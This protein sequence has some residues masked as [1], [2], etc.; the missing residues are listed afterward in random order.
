MQKNLFK[1]AA[2]LLLV[3]LS[4]CSIFSDKKEVGKDVVA[5]KLYADAHDEL[6][7]GAYEQ[8]IHLFEQLE[9]N[10]PFGVY[11]QQAQM[12]IAYAYYRKGEP[13]E[14][15][16]AAERFIKLHPK[17]PNVEYVYYLRGLIN[18]SDSGNFLNVL[19]NQDL[20][21]RDPKAIREAFDAFKQLTERF[22]NSIY[23]PD[24]IARMKYLVNAM[25]Q[26]E[27]HVAKYYYRRGAYLAAVNRAQTAVND[28]QGAPATEEALFVMVRSYDKM[29]L[30][31]LRDDA[32]RVFK[33]NYPNS[34][35]LKNDGNKKPWWKI[36]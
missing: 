11:A 10:Y 27:V 20:T 33:K 26:Y 1:L 30:N 4:A 25:A 16:A 17:H 24:A 15:L 29:G 32:D 12:E 31:T 9:S 34:A 35:F 19:F 13:V 3:A 6:S 23:T 2:I 36:L 18:F 14:A 8:A 5:A 7:K 22:P 21:E 28:Y